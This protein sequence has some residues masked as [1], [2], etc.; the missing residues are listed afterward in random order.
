MGGMLVVSPTPLCR[1]ALCAT[2][3]LPLCPLPFWDVRSHV[4]LGTE[5]TTK[6]TLIQPLHINSYCGREFISILLCL[7][8][9]IEGYL[10][11]LMTIS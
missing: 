9:S 6:H 3:V 4:V 1:C 8:K 7:S 11:N 10:S 5:Q 2:A